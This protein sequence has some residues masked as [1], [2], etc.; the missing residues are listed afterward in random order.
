MKNAMTTYASSHE[1]TFMP[2]LTYKVCQFHQMIPNVYSRPTHKTFFSVQFHVFLG[3]VSVIH[4]SLV[5]AVR[6]G[7]RPAFGL[8][9]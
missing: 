5:R 7:Q 3:S 1:R 8:R 4:T 9:V 2:G 6:I